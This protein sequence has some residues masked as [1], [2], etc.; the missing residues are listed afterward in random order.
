M[1]QASLDFAIRAWN[2]GIWEV[3]MPDGGNPNGSVTFL[4]CWEPL[5]YLPRESSFDPADEYRFVHREDRER[6]ERATAAYLSE[7]T[8]DYDIEYRLRHKDGS[9]RWGSGP[10]SR[11]PR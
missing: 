11:R 5:G 8:K 4:N 9:Y 2:I 6:L 7:E 1:A 3:N 10:R